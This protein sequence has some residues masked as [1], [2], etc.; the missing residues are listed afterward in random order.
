MYKYYFEKLDVWTLA[1]DFA[2]E[3]YVQTESFPST[4]KYGITNQIRRAVVSVPTNLA[5]GSARSTSKDQANFSTIAYSSLMETLNLLIISYEL[6]YLKAEEYTALRLKIN[7]IAN[8]INALRN[9]Q[10]GKSKK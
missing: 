8:K 10:L 3:I 7:E 4:E 6:D 2:K 9:S 5:E 1:K